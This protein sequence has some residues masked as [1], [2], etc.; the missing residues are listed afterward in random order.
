MSALRSKFKPFSKVLAIQRLIL[1]TFAMVGS[2]SKRAA[3]S[4][5]EICWSKE[6]VM[7]E[8][9]SSCCLRRSIVVEARSMSHD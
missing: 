8:G 1:A 4:Q 2:F 7:N 5:G 6:S 3:L 9:L